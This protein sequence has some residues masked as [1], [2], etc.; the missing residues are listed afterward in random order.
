MLLHQGTV[1]P[2][3]MVAVM[4]EIRVFL[5]TRFVFPHHPFGWRCSLLINHNI[6]GV[7]IL[8]LGC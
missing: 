2:L 4:I 7:L 6:V 5:L 8:W 3:I 1:H